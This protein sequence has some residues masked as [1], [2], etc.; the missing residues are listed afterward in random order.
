[1][2]LALYI[3]LR[4]LVTQVYGDTAEVL[5]SDQIV[6]LL[7]QRVSRA[8]SPTD[9]NWLIAEIL[10]AIRARV[11]PDQVIDLSSQVG[12]AVRRQFNQKLARRLVPTTAV[13]GVAAS[14]YLYLVA[15]VAVP[16]SVASSWS[17]ERIST[18]RVDLLWEVVF[19]CGPYVE[20]ALF[21]GVAATAIFL[22]LVLTDERYSVALTDALLHEPAYRSLAVGVPYLALM[23]DETDPDPNTPT[24]TP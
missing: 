15:A 16:R 14:L 7:H 10:P 9:A 24:H 18:T 20:V 11:G 2:L 8:T 6:F 22:A 23:A 19:P 4:G 17:G 3:R 13:V 1:M 5:A 12:E 21:L